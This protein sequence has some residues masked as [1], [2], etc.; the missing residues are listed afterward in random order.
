MTNWNRVMY[1]IDTVSTSN[2]DE[3]DVDYRPYFTRT[4]LTC[5]GMHMVDKN[6][7]TLE[8]EQL[9]AHGTSL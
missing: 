5:V 8:R 3:I 2:L 1:V 6:G 7:G 9:F 4:L